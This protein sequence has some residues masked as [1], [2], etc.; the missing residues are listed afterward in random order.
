MKAKKQT[1]KTIQSKTAAKVIA[2]SPKLSLAAIASFVVLAILALIL[3]VSF[4]S[5]S[6][7]QQADDVEAEYTETVADGQLTVSLTQAGVTGWQVVKVAD[8]AECDDNPFETA[9]VK[10]VDNDEA[11]QSVAIRYEDDANY[12][13]WPKR[14][15]DNVKIIYNYVSARYIQQ[16]DPA[17]LAEID[18]TDYEYEVADG[19][20]TVTLNQGEA[21]GWQVIKVT[22]SNACR[23]DSFDSANKVAD[24]DTA[25]DSVTITY[26]DGA[27]YCFWPKRDT[28]YIKV[29]LSYMSAAEIARR[30]APGQSSAPADPPTTATPNPGSGTTPANPPVATVDDLEITGISQAEAGD[31]TVLKALANRPVARGWAI[32]ADLLDGGSCDASAFA[33]ADFL[34]DNTRVTNGAFEV[35]VT[36]ADHEQQFCFKVEE[37]VA[38]RIQAAYLVSGSVDLPPANTGQETGN[39]SGTE[40]QGESAGTASGNNAGSSSSTSGGTDDDNSDD[41]ASSEAGDPEEDEGISS[42]VLLTIIAGAAAI[43]II[44]IFVVVI[45]VSKTGRPKKF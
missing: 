6:H 43:G 1:K 16:I 35:V 12:C 2:P 32:R 18:K 5:V 34:H 8:K 23:R 4:G 31:Q 41:S 3:A 28:D 20:L 10:V 26:E 40:A 22:D 37:D 7:G 25:S 30:A 29:V 21:N 44:S 17:N 11:S 13:F 9:T 36:P 45:G 42:T 33:D 27:N 38:G 39:E 15:T 24:T 14:D 19:Q